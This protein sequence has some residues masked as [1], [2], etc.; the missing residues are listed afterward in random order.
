MHWR[1]NASNRSKI[2]LQNVEHKSNCIYLF[3]THKESTC[4]AFPYRPTAIRNLWTLSRLGTASRRQL[5]LINA[6][7]WLGGWAVGQVSRVLHHS[8]IQWLVGFF[9]F[10][11]FEMAINIAFVSNARPV[12]N[13][14]PVCSN[15]SVLT[16]ATATAKVT[17]TATKTHLATCLCSSL[18]TTNQ[19]HLTQPD[20]GFI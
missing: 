10:F 16:A 2:K 12:A 20:T 4:H 5:W 14:I 7:R 19:P 13:L 11:S 9:F 8:F 6:K 18:C 3:V 17:A 15:C 1:S